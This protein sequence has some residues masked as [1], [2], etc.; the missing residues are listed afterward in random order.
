MNPIDSFYTLHKPKFCKKKV[1]PYLDWGFGLT[2]NKR[3]KTVSILAFAWDRIIQLIYIN[4]E[5]T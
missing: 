1:L 5:G 4:E 3:D 2:P